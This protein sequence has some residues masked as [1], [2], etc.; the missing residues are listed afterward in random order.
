MP[1]AVEDRPR[2]TSLNHI[3][4]HLNVRHSL[5]YKSRF[6]NL[7]P[8]CW[9]WLIC[10]LL[11]YLCFYANYMYLC[12]L[13]SNQFVM[14]FNKHVW[15]DTSLYQVRK[16]IE[17]DVFLFSNTGGSEEKKIEYTPNKSW[18]CN[19]TLGVTSSDALPPSQRRLVERKATIKTMFLPA[20]HLSWVAWENS[21]HL[22]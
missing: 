8:K 21:R 16:K 22:E 3:L 6:H 12:L 13:K 9:I 10:F 17:K 11:F 2:V 4:W 5:D 20:L 14:S 7:T 15:K 1:E 19:M 18:T